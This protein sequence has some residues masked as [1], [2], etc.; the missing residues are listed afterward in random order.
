MDWL[1]FAVG[2]AVA[3]ATA[4]FSVKLAAGQI[5][6]QIGALIYSLTT[7]VIASGWVLISRANGA[8]LK[9][10]P[11]GLLPAL[12]TGVAFAF[13]TIFLYLTFATGVNISL[14]IPT[15]RIAGILLASALGVLL[16]GEPLTWRYVAGV[17][18]ALAGIYLIATR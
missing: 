11:E 9:F 1:P 12:V 4:D 16:L 15:I 13:V 17:A 6:S 18:L 14:A 10:T 7:L 8:A 3:L 5:G 2:A